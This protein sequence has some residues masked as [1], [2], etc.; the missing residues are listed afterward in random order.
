M[1]RSSESHEYF[2]HY[3]SEDS[4]CLQ[5]PNA[6]GTQRGLPPNIHG[7]V[8]NDDLAPTSDW[9]LHEEYLGGGMF[10]IIINLWL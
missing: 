4:M 1:F 3:Q 6:P 7:G 9:K 5:P 10:S 2:I 8:P